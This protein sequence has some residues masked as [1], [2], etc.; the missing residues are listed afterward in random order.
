MTCATNNELG[1]IERKTR[2][3]REICNAAFANTNK[4][5]PGLF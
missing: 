4:G 5:K 2:W 1:L 3:R